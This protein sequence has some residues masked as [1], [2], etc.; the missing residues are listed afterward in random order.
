MRGKK[1]SG[2]QRRW[3]ESRKQ[4]NAPGFWQIGMRKKRAR[5][6]ISI[7]ILKLLKDNFHALRGLWALARLDLLLWRRMPLAIA[8]ALI[9]PIG[10]AVM[11]VALS[12]AVTQEPVALVIESHGPSSLHMAEIIKADTDAYFLSVTDMQDAQR[13]LRD[14]EIAAIIIIPADFEQKASSHT[15][16]LQLLLNNI[17]IDFSDDIRRSVERS[18]AQF[19]APQL[20]LEGQ[21]NTGDSNATPNPY[22]INIDER[23]LRET[24]VNF[25]A[26]QVLPD[27]VLLVLSTGLMGTALLCAQDVERGKARH[28]VLAPLS[29]WVLV[30]GRLLGGFIAS[31]IVLIPAIALCLIIGIISPPA[32]HWPALI[33]I[34]AATALGASSL[35]AI[36]G[37]LLRG[38]RNI[39]LASSLLATYLFFLGGGFTIIQ[40]L[41][42]WLR[43]ISAFNPIRYA[44]DGMRQALFYPDLSGFSTDLAVLLGTALLAM[45]VGSVAVRRSWS[46]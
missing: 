35:G 1:S 17:D 19:D 38:T 21:L 10:M 36:L 2:Q 5:R 31:L 9:P 28:L 42:Q 34:F 8:S 33:A 30:A 4:R 32:G 22:H 20:S 18:I 40:F 44:I 15:A 13:M 16:S 46:R 26:Y 6:Q 43:T 41:P 25:L 3:N 14:Q 11:L 39:A 23:N 27:L 12:F 37:T 24:N 7:D 29:A 45:V